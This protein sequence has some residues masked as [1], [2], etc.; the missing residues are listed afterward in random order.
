MVPAERGCPRWR[1][2]RHQ[3][4]PSFPRSPGIIPVGHSKEF[5]DLRASD[6][7]I[8]TVDHREVVLS[9]GI[10]TRNAAHRHEDLP[11]AN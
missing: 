4:P 9:T 8:G 10:G 6:S 2:G 5:S 7:R 11:N 1:G 3:L